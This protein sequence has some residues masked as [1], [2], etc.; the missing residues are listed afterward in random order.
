VIFP[1]GFAVRICSESDFVYVMALQRANRESV[2]GLPGPALRERIAKRAALLGLLNGDPCGY[3]LRDVGRDRVLRIPQACIQYDA[4]RRAYGA[5]LVG[6]ALLDFD[7]EEIRVRCAADLE[8][9]LFWRDL[10]FTCTATTPG[11][12]RRG[13]T[14]NLWQKWLTPRLIGADEIAVAPVAQRREDSMY[15]ETDYLLSTPDGFA[16]GG[17]LGKLAWSNRRST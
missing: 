16:D 1:D 15:D 9:N 7:G 11:G 3:I 4:R 8:A 2:G 6:A 5:A 12:K 17:S 13:R 10:G 14:L